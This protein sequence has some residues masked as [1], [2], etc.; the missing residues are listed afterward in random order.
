MKN[1]FTRENVYFESEKGMLYKGDSLTML[2]ALPDACVDAIITDP[3]YNI[4]ETAKLCK[5]GNKIVSNKEMW[6]HFEPENTADWLGYLDKVFKEFHRV[7]KGSLII[8]YDRFEIT[9]IKDMLGQAG[10]YP[11]NLLCIVKKNPLP[12]FRKNGFRSDFELALYCQ[13]IKGKDTFNFLS[14]D[15]MKSVDYYVI[16]KK[17]TTHPTEKPLEVIKKYV[18]IITKE[19]DIVLD[20]FIGSGTTALACEQTGRKWLG[21][22]KDETYCQMVKRTM[23]NDRTEQDLQ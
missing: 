3:P 17:R 15:Q 12:H 8:F 20:A 19:G 22:E 5:K 9:R 10:F 16:G 13:K 2:K 21:I 4:G 6:G 23:T 11:K 7:V 14:Q 1:N 18:N